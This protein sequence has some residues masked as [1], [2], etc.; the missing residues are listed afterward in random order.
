MNRETI[1]R[2]VKEM[3]EHNLSCYSKN[4]LCEKPKDG[5]E[6]KWQEAKERLQ[7]I[8]RMLDELPHLVYDQEK[9][10]SNT[11]R[12]FCGS[13]DGYAIGTTHTEDPHPYITKIDFSVDDGDNRYSDDIRYLFEIDHQLGIDWFISGWYDKERHL[14]YG[15]SK[16]HTVKITVDIINF[17]RKI[18][19]VEQNNK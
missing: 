8:T 16:G 7:L 15:E 3:Q 2:E 14:R 1:L 10:T 6:E 4:Y 19:W 11:V 18:E 12:V 5:Y 17:I 9:D 13:V